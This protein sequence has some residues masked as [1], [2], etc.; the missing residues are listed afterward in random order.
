MGKGIW[1]KVV[2]HSRKVPLYR[3]ED[4]TSE[5]WTT[6][7]HDVIVTVILSLSRQHNNAWKHV[8][9]FPVPQNNTCSYIWERDCCSVVAHWRH[10]IEVR[11]LRNHHV[12][13]LQTTTNKLTDTDIEFNLTFKRCSAQQTS[14]RAPL[15]GAA[16]CMTPISLPIYSYMLCLQK[17]TRQVWQDIVSTS[18]DSFW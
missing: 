5:H 7:V 13:R 4:G 8:V 11:L 1:P 17:K 16:T 10:R 9:Q 2:L 14:P 3:W 15:Q 12:A 6:A 18:M